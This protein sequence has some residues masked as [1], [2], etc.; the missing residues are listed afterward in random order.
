MSC[1][2]ETA[3]RTAYGEL[4][5][6]KAFTK[7]IPFICMSATATDDVI[8]KVKS[9]LHLTVPNLIKVNINKQNIS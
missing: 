7:N 9:S 4:G 3:F 5:Q 1:S 8:D 2:E 6:L